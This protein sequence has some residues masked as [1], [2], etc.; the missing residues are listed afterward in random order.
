MLRIY[1]FGLL[2]SGAVEEGWFTASAP[3]GEKNRFSLWQNIP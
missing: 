3:A 1:F 2:K